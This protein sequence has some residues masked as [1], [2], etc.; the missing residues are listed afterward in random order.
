[1][2][3]SPKT[4]AYGSGVK[5]VATLA[6]PI[7]LSMAS[8][9]VM[10]VT[11]T[12]M[13][14]WIG[15]TELAAIGVATTVLF[16]L[17][18]F[19]MGLFEGVK[20]LTAQS[21]G[22]G[23]SDRAFVY[24]FNGL[25]LV[26]PCAVI[27]ILTGF[28]SPTIFRTFGG[29]EQIQSLAVTYFNI[30]V[31]APMFW[32]VSLALTHFFQGLGDT[33]TPMR[34]NI[35]ICALNVAINPI[36]IFGLGPVPA[37]G[38]A[39]SAIAT[40]LSTAV[41]SA[42][43]LHIFF[44]RSSGV[45]RFDRT[46]FSEVVRIG[47]PS[48][49]RWFFDIAGYTM[50]TAIV[51]RLGQIEL[52]ANQICVKIVCLSILPNWGI[53]EA[54]CILTGHHFGAGRFE[55]VKRSFFSGLKVSCSF[56]LLIGIIFLTARPLIVGVFDPDARVYGLAISVMVVVAFFQFFESFQSTCSLAL[57]G[58]GD[59]KFPMF[60]SLLS[61]WFIMLPLAYLLGMKWGLGLVGMWIAATIHLTFLSLA[62]F[63]RF[64]REG[65]R[66]RKFEHVDGLAENASPFDPTG[67]KEPLSEAL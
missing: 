55:Q 67:A 62:V 37:M 9:T 64:M 35:L 6:W 47:W 53:A 51:A 60:A 44:K 29:P 48:G 25:Y 28:L 11:D 21:L 42:I 4:N 20:V 1:M 59:T 43:F 3:Y 10:D 36:F 45:K 26:A 30:R 58:T 19:F 8:H 13:V 23:E 50:F 61:S 7:M 5:D 12:L 27:V 39:G 14:G 22:A 38:V 32:F 16:L 24:G 56:M 17:M 54:T 33:K 40:V 49:V 41:G 66:T 34:I 15:T 65:F 2:S 18:S 46:A 52:A 63:L 31:F 57:Y